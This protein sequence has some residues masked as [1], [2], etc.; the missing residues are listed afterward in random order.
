MLH[1]FDIVVSIKTRWSRCFMKRLL[2]TLINELK[3]FRTAIP[4]HLVV[5]VQPTVMYLLMS[6]ILVHPTFD[7]YITRPS[8]TQ[9]QELVAAMAQVGSPIGAPYIHSIQ[10]GIEGTGRHRQVISIGQQKGTTV[11]VQHYGLIDSNMV[12]NFRNRLTA[13]ALRLWNDHLGDQAV[14]VEEHPWLPT[15]MP[16]TLYFGMAMLPMTIALAGSVVGGVLMAQEFEYGTILEY[17]LA[18]VPTSLV[19]GARLFRLVII[20]LFSGGILL[21][22]LGLL[23]G[24]WPESPEVVGLILLPMSVI[25]GCLGITAGLLTQ[26][27]IP[28][29]LVGLVTTFVGWL[30]G[31]A[32]GLAAGFS[33]AYEFFS[34]L[35]PNTHT[36]ELLYPYFFGADVGNPWSSI[37]T[38][39]AL[40]VSMILITMLVYHQRVIRKL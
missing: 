2:R 23:N 29:F 18:P 34:R 16:Y 28:A 20:S 30:I 6:A 31:S 22:T 11:A 17:R 40:S 9:G 5:M 35:T 15:D 21:V 37:V 19:V 1:F 27:S 33:K 13:A 36:V 32:F 24:V 12:K 14:H 38:L 10:V 39:T 25:A 26:K 4:V 3:L 8:T 7:M